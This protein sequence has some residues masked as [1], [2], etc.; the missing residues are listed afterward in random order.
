M[1]VGGKGGPSSCVP[2]LEQAVDDMAAAVGPH[3]LVVHVL[4]GV[5]H[6]DVLAARFGDQAVLGDVSK[7]AT[8]HDPQGDIVRLTPQLHPQGFREVAD[9]LKLT[10]GETSHVPDELGHTS[11]GRSG[12]RAGRLDARHGRQ[13]AGGYAEYGGEITLELRG[14][15]YATVVDCTEDVERV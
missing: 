8:T 2:A 5:G 11:G 15:L 9:L 14:Q 10:R 7:V 12:R 4:D 13:V 6:V 3:S 1:G